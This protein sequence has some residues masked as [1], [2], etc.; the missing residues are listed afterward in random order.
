MKI[1][2]LIEYLQ[3]RL[4]TIGDLDVAVQNDSSGEL[5]EIIFDEQIAVQ[6]TQE[7]K[8]V[9]AFSATGEWR[10]YRYLNR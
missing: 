3:E 7:G 10:S 5:N 4:E 8:I 9:L 6:R 2:E 1:S